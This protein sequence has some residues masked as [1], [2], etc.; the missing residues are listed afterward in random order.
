MRVARSLEGGPGG[1]EPIST[2]VCDA[3]MTDPGMQTLL[4]H[5]SLF[6]YTKV[7][8]T[9]IHLVYI[10]TPRLHSDLDYT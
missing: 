8:V 10:E 3:L 5:I 6:V 2:A 4:P 9:L 1:N 7:H